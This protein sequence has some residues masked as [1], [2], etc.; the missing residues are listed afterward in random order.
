MSFEITGALPV[1]LLQKYGPSQSGLVIREVYEEIN[2]CIARYNWKTI[3]GDGSKGVMG[4]S[5]CA[6]LKLD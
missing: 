1:L 2:A 4:S 5:D 6:T 3:S